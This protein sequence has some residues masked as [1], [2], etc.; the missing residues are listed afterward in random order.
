METPLKNCM[1]ITNSAGKEIETLLLPAASGTIAASTVSADKY[2]F[3][4]TTSGHRVRL[5]KLMRRHSATVCMPRCQVS[6]CP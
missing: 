6:V 5:M 2:A 3:V 1:Q 4:V